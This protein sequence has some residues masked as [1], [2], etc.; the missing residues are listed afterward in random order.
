VSDVAN[1]V[2]D[3]TD[4]LMLSA[5]TSVGRWPAE[6]V[7]ITG[8]IIVATEHDLVDEIPLSRS[9]PTGHGAAIT[10]AAAAVGSTTGASALV[11]F[12]RSGR[13]ARR[14]S[15]LRHPLPVLVFTPD[16]VVQR[17]LTLTWGVES[18]VAPTVASTDEVFDV[19]DA[20][21]RRRELFHRGDTIVVV[22][23]TPPSNSAGTNT[24]RVQEIR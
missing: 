21:I 3:G 20:V 4:A 24:I 13:T 17:Q 9:R 7:R 11:A 6:A 5:E 19:V 10:R 15:A 14:L 1:A 18:L 16:A 12:T 23:G 22:A 2:L 8:E